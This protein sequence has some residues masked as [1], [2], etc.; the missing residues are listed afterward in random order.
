MLFKNFL[1]SISYSLL[2]I[3]LN[4]CGPSREQ[5]VKD[6]DLEK[7]EVAEKDRSLQKRLQLVRG[8]YPLTYRVGPA[9]EV[10]KFSVQLK[11]PLEIKSLG[12]YNGP[13]LKSPHNIEI[14]FIDKS[15]EPLDHPSLEGSP[16]QSPTNEALKAPKGE[17][18]NFS[19]KYSCLNLDRCVDKLKEVF[20]KAEGVR[21]VNS[22]FSKAS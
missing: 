15:G 12:V 7:L 4:Q 21:I 5:K 13:A 6:L 18:F 22:P 20:E 3:L 19:F 1:R 14:R 16:D 17:K 11:L 10:D 8:K 9:T 2:V